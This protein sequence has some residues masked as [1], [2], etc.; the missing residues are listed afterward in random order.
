MSIKRHCFL[1]G[2]SPFIAFVYN[3]WFE[4]GHLSCYFFATLVICIKYEID[5]YKITSMGNGQHELF[6]NPMSSPKRLAK[7]VATSD[8]WIQCPHIP[9]TSTCTSEGLPV[10]AIHVEGL[11][12]KLPAQK[13]AHAR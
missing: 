5:P 1:P 11:A 13:R 12:R 7:T 3:Y 8:V 2:Q 10:F 6:Q 4:L 9:T